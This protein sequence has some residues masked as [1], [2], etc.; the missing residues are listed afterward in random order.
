SYLEGAGR[1]KRK[2]WSASVLACMQRELKPQFGKRGRLRSSQRRRRFALP[3]HSKRV[4]LLVL[5]YVDV[6][7]VD[8]VV[9]TTAGMSATRSARGRRLIG[10]FT[11][12]RRGLLVE[13]FRHL[14]RNRLQRIEGI[15]HS[16]DAAFFDGLLG[17]GDCG[18]DFAGNRADLL[19]ILAEGLLH[20]IDQT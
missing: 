20:L 7:S 13:S 16:F 8:D 10:G 5:V 18:F 12:R 4:P 1:A 2:D 17:V 3:A 19:T 11:G 9:V 15:V 6:L 14:M